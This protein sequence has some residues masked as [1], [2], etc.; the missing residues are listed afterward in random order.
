[1]NEETKQYFACPKCG[2]IEEYRMQGN[3]VVSFPT[4]KE[5][6]ITK[7]YM[8]SKD[9]VVWGVLWETFDCVCGKC[10][11]VHNSLSYKQSKERWRKE[12]TINKEIEKIIYNNDV[13]HETIASLKEAY[14]NLYGGQKK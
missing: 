3:M 9:F 2:A 7:K 10:G 6:R 5:S 4:Y 13:S 11:Y 8:Q 14:E 1:M 12:D